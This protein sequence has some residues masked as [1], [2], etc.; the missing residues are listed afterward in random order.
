MDYQK[1]KQNNK[2]TIN[3]GSLK[4]KTFSEVTRFHGHVCPG[5]A[6]GY[7][8][9][10]AGLNNLFAGRATDEEIVALVENDSCAVD[11]VQLVTGCTFGKGNLRFND[12]GKQVYTFI[13]RKNGKAV[14][15]SMK[16]SFD[17]NKL[18]PELGSL[19]IK[20]TNGDASKEE[21]EKL[22]M[23]MENVSKKILELP[24]EQI[25]NVEKVNVDLPEKARIFPS[26][27]CSECGEMV[28]EH[29]A[30]FKN[31]KVVCIPCFED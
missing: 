20:V 23:L 17:V 3:N 26:I 15:V 12:F 6:I 21:K 9:S 11:A 5:S 29:R 8:A 2:N 22:G 30:R 16:N 25:F 19:R 24:L 1:N 13:K 4:V 10:E 31:K 27:K 14:R 28:S 7:R 18:E